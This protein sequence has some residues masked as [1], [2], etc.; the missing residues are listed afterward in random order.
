M[1][2]ISFKKLYY[3]HAL[4]E[5]LHYG[6]AA[7]ACAISQPAL[8][9]QIKEL[10]T[11]ICARLIERDTKHLRLTALGVEFA[12]KT[13]LIL[14]QVEDL[15]NIARAASKQFEG[16]L[17]IGAIPT[18]APYLLPSIIKSLWKSYPKIDVVPIEAITSK[19]VQSLLDMKI[20]IAIVA[21]PIE[22]YAFYEVP[23]FEEEFMLVRP[24]SQASEPIPELTELTNHRLLLLE[25]G[26]CFRDQALSF[27]HLNNPK[28][29]NDNVIEGN[30]L[31]TLVQMVSAG[32][33]FTLI[34]KMAVKVESCAANIDIKALPSPPPKRQIGMI[35]RK[36][37]PLHPHFQ[38][39]TD[40]LINKAIIP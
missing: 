36:S 24:S 7:K 8:S 37:N 14:N 39:I 22:E 23:L 26:H 1:N 34:P 40:Y 10:E 29:Q 27:C 15:H 25:E 28:W 38:T 17:T 16:R 33:G 6:K 11:S 3:F 21:L 4:S 13:A 30:S 32:V 12:Q 9:V 20:D 35:W 2:D 19:L 31:S 18:I 5:T